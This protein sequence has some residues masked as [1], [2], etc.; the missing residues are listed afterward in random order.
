MKAVN[1][2]EMKSTDW[3]KNVH[4]LIDA[5]ARGVQPNAI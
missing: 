2:K 1:D 3:I 4:H 5:Q